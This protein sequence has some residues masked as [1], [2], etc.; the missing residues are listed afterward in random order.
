[1]TALLALHLLL[2]VAKAG[3]SLAAGAESSHLNRH[4]QV[5][6]F[7]HNEAVTPLKGSLL[8]MGVFYTQINI[9]TRTF[10]VT[11]DTG[12]TD[13]LVPIDGCDG[14]VP[15]APAYDPI[16]PAEP[17]KNTSSLL[18]KSCTQDAAGEHFC[19]FYDSYL[20]CDLSNLT[21][22]CSVSGKLYRDDVTLGKF[23]AK[24][25]LFG[26]ITKQSSNFDQFKKVDGILGL[27]YKSMGFSD[28]VFESVVAQNQ[29]PNVIQHCLTHEGGLLVYGASPEDD[30]AFYSGELKYTPITLEAWYTVN[31]T[32]L[33]V[34]GVSLNLSLPDINGPFPSDPCIVDSGTN[35]F[36]LTTPSY[37]ATIAALRA[38]GV[39][40]ELLSGSKDVAVD[41]SVAKTWPNVTIVLAPGDVVLNLTPDEYLVPST[42]N[43]PTYRLG[44]TK[45]DC[46][47][48][49][50]HMLRYWTVYDRENARI[51]F[52]E[53][54]KEACAAEYKRRL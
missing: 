19:S 27:A 33:R 53:A 6:H 37:R 17:C 48:G 8:P 12:S 1:M 39:D 13:L 38:A 40:E 28:S 35:F 14:C 43:A 18:C 31:A 34:G 52:A 41:P 49:N 22:L 51:G 7:A 2:V 46:I 15:T 36:S 5:V 11:V 24:N 21:A 26:G 20:T 23:T 4:V 29:I 50:T 32:D 10:N 30:R 42:P 3:S 45:G 54:K 44:I 16:A 47:I 9:G 25:V